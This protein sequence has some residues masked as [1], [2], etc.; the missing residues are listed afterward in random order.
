MK[1]KIDLNKNIDIVI[2]WVDGSDASWLEEKNYWYGKVNP[3]KESNSDIRYQSWDNLKYWFRAVETNL[4]WFNKIFFLT[5]GHIPDFLNLDNPRIKVV[6][7]EDYIP[8]EYLP[9]FNVNTIEM[10]LH[11]IPELSENI[12]YFNDDIFPLIPIAEDYYYKDNKVCDEAIETPIIPVLFG[13]IAKF[14]W[15]MRALDISIIN[16]HFNKREVQKINYDK[17][18][19]AEYGELLE[20]NKS[21]GYWENFVGFR[22]P[23]VSTALKKSTFEKI[24]NSEPDILK[25]TCETKFRDFSCVNQWLVRYWQLCEGDFVPRRTL[26]KSYTVTIHNCE[27]I[28]NVIKGQEHQM[29][30]INEDCTADE[31]EVI[32]S[33]INGAFETLLPNKSSFEK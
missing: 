20:R 33:K 32:K 6:K 28:A 9:T 13:E 16:K 31:F 22:D 26:G 17:W 3:D 2:P 19:C 24:W 5:W 23:H 21:L 4:P 10:N 11:R 29:I 12:V 14:T 27:E 7:H 30:C 8:Q 15:N 18:F 25:K 1:G